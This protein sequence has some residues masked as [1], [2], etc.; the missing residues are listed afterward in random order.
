MQNLMQKINFTPEEQT[1]VI[2]LYQSLSIDVIAQIEAL[3]QQYLHPVGETPTV[4]LDTKAKLTAL[5]ESNGIHPYSLHLLFLLLCAPQIPKGYEEKGWDI[6]YAYNLLMDIRYKLTEC[7]NCYHVIGISTFEWFYR[8]FLLNR[9]ALGY[10]QYDPITWDLDAEYHF[11]D[12]HLAKGDPVYKIHIPSAGKMTRETRLASYCAAHD[13]FGY[14]KGE[15]VALFCRSW[16]LY[17][18]Y[19][20]VYPMNSNLYDFMDDFELFWHG[21]TEQFSDAWRVFNCPYNG[22]TAVLPSETTLQRNFI[23]YINNGG[24]FGSGAGVVICDGERILNNK[25]DNA[26]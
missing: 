19:R 17:E 5:A 8:H 15:P 24:K 20:S 25:R 22:D 7:E 13:F 3:K 23:E 6:K 11:G 18:G 10:F 14:K 12:I 9:F 1:F 21:E 16:L 2:N 26:C 4:N